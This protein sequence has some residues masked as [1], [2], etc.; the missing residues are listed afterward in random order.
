MILV[1]G[2]ASFLGR[3]V[4]R[5]LA[6]KQRPVCCLLRPSPHEQQ[7]P[8]GATFS[9]ISAHPD[10][11]PALQAAMQDVTAIIHLTREEE[12]SQPSTLQEHAEHTRNLIKAAEI[13]DVQQFI[14]LSRLEADRLSAYPLLRAKGEAE[15]A[16]RESEMDYT[17]LRSSIVYGPRDMFTNILVMLAKV[18][19]FILPIPDAGMSRFQP[20]WI[21]D[22]AKCVAETVDRR[23]LIGRTIPLGGPEHFT[24]EQMISQVLEAAGVHRLLVNLRM[25][26]IRGL[27]N[28]LDVLLVH[29]PT[30]PWWLDLVTAGSA[31]ELGTI[32]RHFNFEPR[33]FTQSLTYLRRKRPWRRDFI[34]FV[35]GN[36]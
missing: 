22:L 10:D 21:E 19:P 25:P 8:S 9:T 28:L 23:D 31:T 17:I 14:Y 20:L 4:V 7:L 30:P 36:V 26:L 24:L 15:L 2:A 3:A 32:P 35:L 29:N 11:L 16:V 12:P 34:R 27:V 1:T 5:Q 33:R 18:T 13:A 6:E